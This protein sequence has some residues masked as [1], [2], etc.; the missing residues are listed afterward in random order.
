MQQCRKLIGFQRC[1]NIRSLLFSDN[2]LKLF[3][4]V[5]MNILFPF[6]N[7]MYVGVY[8]W[9]CSVN[10]VL[11]EPDS[12]VLHFFSSKQ[13]INMIIKYVLNK[14]KTDI[15]LIPIHETFYLTMCISMN[16]WNTM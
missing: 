3:T 7:A 11:E 14:I 5:T 10:R 9:V 13:S 6:V 16:P 8:T 15:H 2:Q 4:G 1:V 12:P